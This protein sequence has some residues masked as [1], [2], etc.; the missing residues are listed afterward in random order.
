MNIDIFKRNL[1]LYK[2]GIAELESNEK[3]IYDF[4]INNLTNLNLYTSDEH[5]YI[6]YFGKT[7]NDIFL[8]Y[9]SKNGMLMI[10]YDNIWSFFSDIL[11]MEYSHILQLMRWWVD[12]ALDLKP[13][14]MVKTH[15]IK[16]NVWT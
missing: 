9:N 11:S 14:Y 6:I 13:I 12:V 2:L 5:S 7:I 8:N 3:R 4:L 10:D 15:K 16:K 1:Q